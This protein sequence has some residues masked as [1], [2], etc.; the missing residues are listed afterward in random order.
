[1]LEATETQVLKVRLRRQNLLASEAG[2]DGGAPSTE[3]VPVRDGA[4]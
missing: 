4:G 3:E 2:E 1:V